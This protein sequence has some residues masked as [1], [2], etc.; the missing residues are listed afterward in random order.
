MKR[1]L[2]FLA[3]LAVLAVLT[4]CTA[5][6]TPPTTEAPPVTT[7]PPTEPEPVLVPMSLSELQGLV[8]GLT[9]D[10]TTVTY[11]NMGKADPHRADAAIRADRYLTTLQSFAWE[12][13]DTSIQGKADLTPQCT[14][15]GD[16]FSMTAY[17]NFYV[18]DARP[19]YVATD[20]TG[21]WFQLKTIEETEDTPAQ[22][23]GMLFDLFNS[24]YEEAA[25]AELHQNGGTPIT[26]DELDWFQAFTTSEECHYDEDDDHVWIGATAISC[27]FTSRYDDPRDMDA[28]AFLEYCPP[29]KIL[30]A[31]DEEEFRLVQE[32][33]DWRTSDGELLTIT[34]FP[35]PCRR[36]SRAYINEILT[37]YA[38]LTVEEM[39]TD[40]LEAA[41]YVPA[42]DCFYVF[43]SDFGP[44]TFAPCYGEHTGDTV[45]LWESPHANDGKTSDV[46]ILQK[47][48]DQWHILS[49]QAAE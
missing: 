13:F 3:A 38:G 49:H 2:F 32:K 11:L 47:T 33:L 7:E 31:A 17:R 21:G 24:W 22:V 43:T 6:P 44:G 46:L 20:T 5:A 39:H 26:A 30:D 37:Q 34:E 35:F 28:N 25:F 4:G 19:V 36:L 9:T 10:D 15:S 48:N 42:T 27:F 45:T 18:T 40:W 1:I 23:P 14:L 41:F 12:P 29:E 8:K 16:G